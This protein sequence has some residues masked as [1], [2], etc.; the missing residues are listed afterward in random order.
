[1]VQASSVAC[2]WL[3]CFHACQFQSVNCVDFKL[4][5]KITLLMSRDQVCQRTKGRMHIYFYNIK[6]NISNLH[7]CI[8]QISNHQST[9]I[10]F[11]LFPAVMVVILCHIAL[12]FCHR[13]SIT[14]TIT[15]RQNQKRVGILNSKFRLG[16]RVIK[17][18]CC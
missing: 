16:R 8:M 1:M 9:N 4:S 18:G 2:F 15:T 5:L 10:Y 3:Q 6:F 17:R 12:S 14:V 11:L 7:L 13:R